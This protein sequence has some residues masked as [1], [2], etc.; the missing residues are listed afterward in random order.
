MR[1]E[2]KKGK[3]LGFFHNQ[4]YIQE[5]K[6]RDQIAAGVRHFTVPAPPPVKYVRTGLPRCVLGGWRSRASR[7][8]RVRESPINL[9][10]QAFDF[11]RGCFPDREM[12]APAVQS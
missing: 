4:I 7:V 12:F 1:Y 3:L 2:S 9:G 8:L 11:V 5:I 6:N 10:V